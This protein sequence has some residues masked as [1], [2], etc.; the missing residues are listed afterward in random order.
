VKHLQAL[1]SL[2]E[3]IREAFGPDHAMLNSLQTQGSYGEVDDWWATFEWSSGGMVHV[4]I[5]FWIVASPRIDKVLISTEE[6][7]S[8]A[9]I[10]LVWDEDASVVL[11]DD[12][13]A[14]VL[15]KF[16]DR[17]YTEWNPFKNKQEEVPAVGVR[18]SMGKKIEKTKQL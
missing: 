14:R 10:T 8:D 6:T 13:A 5:A 4:H 18:R 1:K 7:V 12:A 16:Y 3:E 2:H 15:T 17:V 11:N 9:A